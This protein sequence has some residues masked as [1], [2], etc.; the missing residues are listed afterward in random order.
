MIFNICLVILRMS[1]NMHLVKS[2]SFLCNTIAYS[3]GSVFGNFYIGLCAL[4]AIIQNIWAGSRCQKIRISKFSF[5]LELGE[6]HGMWIIRLFMA[7]YISWSHTY[8]MTDWL[9]VLDL[10]PSKT[11]QINQNH[12]N[13][14]I[15]TKLTENADNTDNLYNAYNSNFN[16][17]S[18]TI[19]VMPYHF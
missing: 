3:I 13:L 19:L 4:L 6:H 17:D 16:Q 18:F 1:H 9:M 5:C 10:E 7:L 2:S 14:T 15:L 12:K 8:L 11:K